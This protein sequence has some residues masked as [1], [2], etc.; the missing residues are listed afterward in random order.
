MK[1]LNYKNKKIW[2]GLVLVAVLAVV[3]LLRVYAGEK[4]PE[5][6]YSPD[7]FAKLVSKGMPSDIEL[8]GSVLLALEQ[9]VRERPEKFHVEA[10]SG[11][12]GWL[13]LRD[14]L[15]MLSL[16]QVKPVLRSE[17][18]RHCE[19]MGMPN[20]EIVIYKGIIT[21]ETPRSPK[22]SL[23]HCLSAYLLVADSLDGRPE[24]DQADIMLRGGQKYGAVLQLAR[25]LFKGLE[26]VT[27]EK[28]TQEALPVYYALSKAGRLESA[29]GKKAI[30][31]CAYFGLNPLAD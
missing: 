21:G 27:L 23:T 9:H 5:P 4:L 10:V 15:K 12:V 24:G 29:Q 18:L 14:E 26:D 11:A 30:R 1:K 7:Y 6:Y 20:H 17:Y 16:D 2:I 13:M 19:A 22:D 8:C 3:G 25:K 28:I 31:H